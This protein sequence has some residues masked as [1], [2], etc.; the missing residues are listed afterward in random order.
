VL[1]SFTL[2]QPLLD[3]TGRSPELFV[4]NRAGRLEVVAFIVIVVAAPPMLLWLLEQTVAVWSGRVASGLH[5]VFLALLITA[6]V[7][8]IGKQVA[9]LQGFVLLALALLLGVA[10]AVALVRNAKARSYVRYL[11]PAPLVFALLFI[12]T[13]PAGALVLPSAEGQ[14]A[15]ATAT[16]GSKAPVVMIVFDELP[17]MGLLDRNGRV[18]ERLFP[19]FARFADD[20]TWFRNATAVTGLTVDA[21]PALLSGRYPERSIAATHE[22]YPETLFSMLPQQYAITASETVTQL[23]APSR[24]RKLSSGSRGIGLPSV[25]RDVA[26]TAKQ[27][28]SPFASAADPAADQFVERTGGEGEGEGEGETG[29][30]VDRKFRYD[31]LRRN[32]PDRFTD[33]LGALDGTDRPTFHFLNLLLPHLPYRYLP[34]E[35]TYERAPRAFTYKG[36]PKPGGRPGS[37][38]SNWQRYLLQLAYTDRLVGDVIDQLKAQDMYDD[39]LIVLTSDHG[40]GIPAGTPYRKLVEENT[41]ALAFVPVFVKAPNQQEG[42]VDDRNFELVDLLPTVADVIDVPVPWKHDGLSGFGD[43]ERDRATKTW[44]N[45]PG[46]PTPFRPEEPYRDVLRG[47]TDELAQPELGVEGLFHFGDRKDLVGRRVDSFDRGPDSDGSVG[48]QPGGTLSVNRDSGTIPAMVW[49][50]V[51]GIADGTSVAVA[52][53]GVVAAVPTVFV[54]SETGQT[55]LAGMVSER[56]LREGENEVTAYVVEGTGQSSRL[57]S[58]ALSD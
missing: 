18:D 49:G 4:F 24:C 26:A 10:A 47:I 45:K 33:F 25:L 17:L 11:V 9:P 35:L 30:S 22:E 54:D 51:A 13:S 50:E 8:E 5:T 48:I 7:I 21:L 15:R 19:N 6:L 40:A 1:T 46:Q 55:R 20:S 14:V 34:S 28:V 41:A 32:Q 29:G 36:V 56:L 27:V 43:V 37:E 16:E 57:R 31:E 3:L 23:C 2:A 52:V 58:I 39:A 38:Q 12:T 42:V 44:F 53:N